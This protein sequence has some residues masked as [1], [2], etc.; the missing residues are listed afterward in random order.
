MFLHITNARYV[1]GYKVEVSFNNGRKGIADL[2]D[3]LEGPMFEPLRNCS[4]FSALTVDRELET[5][6]WPNGADL[7]PE[8]IYFQVFK[9]DPELQPQFKRWGYIKD[10][11]DCPHRR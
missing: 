3:A 7:A 11:S 8:Y 2:S 5:I 6:V 9:D 4:I 1:E 10:L